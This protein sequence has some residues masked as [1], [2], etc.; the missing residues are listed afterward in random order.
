MTAT[1]LPPQHPSTYLN[2]AQIYQPIPMS[3]S[4][5]SSAYNANGQQAA[6]IP[7]NP[8][9]RQQ[10]PHVA[11]PSSKPINKHYTA[12]QKPKLPTLA[13]PGN[14][15]FG[16]IAVDVHH[17]GQP[18]NPSQHARQIPLLPYPTPSPIKF[19]AMLQRASQ[20][21]ERDLQGVKTLIRERT[22]PDTLKAIIKQSTNLD[23]LEAKID[24]LGLGFEKLLEFS[25]VQMES[26][27]L[28]RGLNGMCDQQALDEESNVPPMQGLGSMPMLEET[29]ESAVNV[30]G[31]SKIKLQDRKTKSRGDRIVA[32]YQP[33]PSRVTRSRA[34]QQPRTRKPGSRRA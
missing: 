3:Q 7:R 12:P 9:Q 17:S 31:A 19:D 14:S 13:T 1:M 34:K 10:Q 15:S 5:F 16:G 25:K 30:V 23:V 20:N 18:G 33:T 6:Q 32:A 11:R 29:R 28:Q 4:S 21:F 27:Q 22:D 2:P 24:E 8:T 26:S